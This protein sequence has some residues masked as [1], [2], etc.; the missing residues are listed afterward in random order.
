[1]HNEFTQDGSQEM[2]RRLPPSA[3]WVD[4]GKSERFWW[5]SEWYP[6]EYE[7][8]DGGIFQLSDASQYPDFFQKSEKGL[9]L[10][11]IYTIDIVYLISGLSRVEASG[12]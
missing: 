10:M 12:H 5:R 9:C 6:A 4:H 11:T 1:M 7:A 2:M 3:K 8:Y